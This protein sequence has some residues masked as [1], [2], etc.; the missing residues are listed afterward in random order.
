MTYTYELIDIDTGNTVG[1][2]ATF[3]LGRQL[4]LKVRKEAIGLV[5]FEDGLATHAWCFEDF[6]EEETS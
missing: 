1:T 6:V 4:L 5:E 3:E 2:V